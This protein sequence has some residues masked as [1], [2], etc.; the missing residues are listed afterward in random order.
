[1]DE[2]ITGFDVDDET[3]KNAKDILSLEED[4]TKLGEVLS[5]KYYQLGKRV[6][7]ITEHESKEINSLVDRLVEAKIKL[8]NMKNQCVCLNCMAQNPKENAYCGKCGEILG[9]DNDE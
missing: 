8:S 1:M 6:Y 7:E 3:L 4:I 9:R 2:K 5:A